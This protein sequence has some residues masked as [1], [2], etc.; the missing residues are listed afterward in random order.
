MNVVYSCE[1][2]DLNF[3]WLHFVMHSRAVQSTATIDLPAPGLRRRAQI[4]AQIIA[5]CMTI[6]ISSARFA[7]TRKRAK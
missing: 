7:T 3:A 5:R 2:A 6:V 1:D 4:S